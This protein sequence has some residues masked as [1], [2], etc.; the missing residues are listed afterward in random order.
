MDK[1]L[2]KSLTEKN[3]RQTH[4]EKS[5]VS[6]EQYCSH[7]GFKWKMTIGFQIVTHDSK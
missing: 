4:G 1:V 3:P 5:S 2:I 7:A 6:N